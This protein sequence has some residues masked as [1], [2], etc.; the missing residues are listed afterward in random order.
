LVSLLITGYAEKN[1]N[2]CVHMTMN[3]THHEK[4]CESI[5]G[6]EKEASFLLPEEGRVRERERV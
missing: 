1:N 5:R 3:F 6:R 2:F 4:V